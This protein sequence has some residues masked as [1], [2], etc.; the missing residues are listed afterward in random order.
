MEFFDNDLPQIPGAEQ[1]VVGFS[2]D[3]NSNWSVTKVLH[4][5]GGGTA[6]E[7]VTSQFPDAP[8]EE[9]NGQRYW[10]NGDRA[11]FAP[12][13]EGKTLIVTSADA[14]NDI[15]D[16]AGD[17]PPLRRDVE[18]L[19]AHTDADRDATIVFTPNS[20]FSEARGIFEGEMAGLRQPLFWFLG[21]EL[22]AAALSL[23][24][25]D[26]FYVELIATPTLD[27]SPERAARLLAERV[28]EIPDKL[29][30][31]VVALE[32]H[33][34]GRVIVARFPAMVRK[35]SA[36]TRSGFESDHVV[37][38]AYLPAV[39]GHNLL[40]G[41]ELTLAESV[42]TYAKASSPL[43]G[44]NIGPLSVVER[45]R[46]PTT[47]RFARD[48]LD[49]A[50]HQLSQDLGVVIDIRGADL[51]ADGITKNQSFGIDAT[52]K[53]AEEVLLEILSLANPDKTAMGPRDVKQKLV[54]VIEKRDDGSERIVVTTRTAVAARA[55]ELPSVFRQAEP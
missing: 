13:A 7:Y 28:A 33:P 49:A 8:Q 36:Y 2:V 1:A 53:P 27:T 15:I 37:L 46:R 48:T 17:P 22:S 35:L 40:I 11:Y 10:L 34:Y 16:L 14:V 52:D 20:L 18:R 6:S 31:S 21:D 41:A 39:A 50:L 24:W 4:I 29:E 25:G 9:H 51:Q 19:L 12:S 3:R 26:D 42:G 54:Y 32:P 38:N 5:S 43:K 44:S 30:A 47:L 55:E 23:D 45:L